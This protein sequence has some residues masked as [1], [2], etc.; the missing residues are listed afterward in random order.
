MKI[1]ATLRRDR[2]FALLAIATLAIGIGACTAV[3]TLTDSILL[4]PLS[5]P[6]PSRL[7]SIH[8]SVPEFAG[9]Y[10]VIPVNAASFAAWR[11]RSRTLD[12]LALVEPDTF[13]LSGAGEPRQVVVDS[14]SASLLHVLR[15]A[16][17][18]GRDFTP[19][20][21]QPHA[22]HVVILTDAFWRSQF[23]ADPAV[24]GR[25]LDLN[26]APN[27]IIGVLPPSF[28]FPQGE[29]FGPMIAGNAS[30]PVQML[31]PIGLDLVHP[32]MGSWNYGVFARLQPGAGAAQA[33][34]E[35]QGITN[36]L[37]TSTQAPIKRVDVLV[38]SLRDQIVGASAFGLWLLLAAVGAILLIVCLNLANLMLV[39]MQARSHQLAIMLALGIRR[40][41]LLREA[42]GEG[43]ALALL[44]GAAG[45]GLAWWAVR[46]VVALAPAALPRL[47]EVGMHPLVLAFALLLALASGAVF[48]LAA[49]LRAA[50]TDPQTAL[51]A[52]GRGLSEGRA[53]LRARSCLIAAQAA[54]AS[55]LLIVAGLLASSYWHLMNVPMGFD[56]AG[57][58]T[59]QVEWFAG[60]RVQRHDFYAA[61]LD[62]LAA[63]PGVTAAGL[64]SRL[65]LEASGDTSVLSMP[66]DT[67][68]MA[69]RPLAQRRIASP[70]YFAAMGIPLLR[71][72]TFTPA[73]LAAAA[74]GK[75]AVPALISAR[76]AA[77]IWPGRD[78]IGQQFTWNS[79]DSGPYNVVIGVVGDVRS[80]DLGLAPEF[81]AYLPYTYGNF[82][83]VEFVLR[84]TSAPAALAAP[85]RRTLWQLQ[86]AVAIPQVA[87][88]QAVVAA[89]T[90]ARRFQ[91]WLVLGFAVCALLLA[92]LGIYGILAYAVERRRTEIGIRM[93][94]GAQTASL[95]AMVL[96]QGLTPV[97][98]G[99]AVGV[100]AAEAGGRLLASLLFGVTPA[101]PLVMAAVILLLVAVAALACALPA[102]RATRV[103][104][105]SVLRS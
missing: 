33:R 61:A 99:L 21:D 102:R 30:G 23:H 78:P 89:S 29:E 62:R 86:P 9:Q 13:D 79:D 18:L 58:L 53:R 1:L 32:E 84:T 54:L 43:I 16:P 101:D 100:A 41:R 97:L 46:A 55:L 66:H 50:R 91:L 70:G 80:R 83:P 90:A 27:Q 51:R 40:A 85:L 82:T 42:M 28:R 60:G 22:N 17:R 31:R 35:L 15:V 8:E 49:A 6:Q 57:T 98:A 65:P 3:F 71:G 87:T 20:E 2:G 4:R 94:L 103:N 105:V 14:V 72:R 93:T 38:T 12:S 74:D 75:S 37:L 36:A 25:S 39:R 47:A 68:P 45:L 26:G 76:A 92:A 52:G 64:I 67:R 5:Y 24:I 59:A 19:A 63:L 77:Q 11:E 88:M 104:P 10:P 44:G 95:I 34:A 96:R 73:D 81:A 69:Q 56:P 7:I 48:S